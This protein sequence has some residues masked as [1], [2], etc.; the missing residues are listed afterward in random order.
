MDAPANVEWTASGLTL[1]TRRHSAWSV[2]VGL[3]L[4]G[5]AVTTAVGTAGWLTLGHP[6]RAW[7]LVAAAV[8]GFAVAGATGSWAEQRWNGVDQV[9]LDPI[10]VRVNGHQIRYEHIVNVAWF[11]STLEIRA[12]D[13]MLRVHAP[14]LK[15]RRTRVAQQPDPR[16]VGCVS[17]APRRRSRA[18]KEILAPPTSN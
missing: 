11:R 16:F 6:D 7:I 18:L 3:V 8:G 2:V 17:V 15:P 14:R 5:A 10:G 9:E 4:A 1:E 13:R 12:N